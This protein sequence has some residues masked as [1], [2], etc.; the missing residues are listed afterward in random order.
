MM[1]AVLVS[2]SYWYIGTMHMVKDLS[3]NPVSAKFW[4]IN[5]K[6]F[7]EIIAIIIW[8]IGEIYDFQFRYGRTTRA[9]WMS[10]FSSTF[11]VATLYLL[12]QL[13]CNLISQ[14]NLESIL[15]SIVYAVLFIAGFTIILPISGIISAIIF[16]ICY[17]F[18]NLIFPFKPRTQP[19]R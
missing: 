2:L 14:F 4:V 16:G 9:T 18:F 7:S 12:L 15:A 19:P 3:A 1:A 11:D 8:P 10:I 17:F 13:S 5:K 6:P